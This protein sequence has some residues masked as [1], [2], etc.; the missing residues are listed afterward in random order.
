MASAI[1]IA[2]RGGKVTSSD[3]TDNEHRCLD[4][5]QQRPLVRPARDHTLHRPRDRSD[6]NGFQRGTDMRDDLG[7]L[8]KGG[9]PQECLQHRPIQQRSHPTGPL[10][11]RKQDRE[12]HLLADAGPTRRAIHQHRSPDPLGI[13]RGEGPADHAAPGIADEVRLVDTEPIEDVDHAAGTVVETEQLRQ[14]LATAL[15]GRVDQHHLPARDEIAGH[16][17]PHVT[18]HQQAGP[19]NDR[20]TGSPYL[21]PNS[22]ENSVH[23]LLAKLIADA[24]HRR[25][26]Y[27]DSTLTMLSRSQITSSRRWHS[28]RTKRSPSRSAGT[29]WAL[30]LPICSAN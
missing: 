4:S 26:R 11:Q 18:G 9:R 2:S 15:P 13:G 12:L 1:A 21:Q 22:A 29:A 23:R 20:R 7:T 6:V 27:P 17:V 24:G 19:E 28:C 10:R 30:R 8:P 5:A 14:R 25:P 3:T 16:P